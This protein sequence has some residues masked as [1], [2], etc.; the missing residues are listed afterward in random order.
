VIVNYLS[1]EK[2]RCEV[3]RRAKRPWMMGIGVSS[4]EYSDEL[5]FSSALQIL[6]SK[7]M[8]LVGALKQNDEE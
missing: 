2:V 8:M 5:H 3:I 1:I 4:E 7:R 6:K